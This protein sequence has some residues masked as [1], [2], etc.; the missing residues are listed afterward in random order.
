MLT[1]GPAFMA[2][3]KDGNFAAAKQLGPKKRC[4]WMT[5]PSVCSS[6][7]GLG[8][9][10]H[11]G[12]QQGENRDDCAEAMPRGAS[13]EGGDFH[14]EEASGLDSIGKGPGGFIV[15]AFHWPK[16]LNA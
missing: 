10:H 9:G 7:F 16:S 4:L 3:L 8:W 12:T 14:G 6:V 1:D 5:C 2:L 15:V 13:C 11:S